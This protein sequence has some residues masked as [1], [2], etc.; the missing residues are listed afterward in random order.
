[1]LGPGLPMAQPLIPNN[2]ANIMLFFTALPNLNLTPDE[3][4]VYGQLFKQADTENV[5]VVTGEI[6][7]KFFEKTRLDSR[8]LGEVGNP[9]SP[10][11]LLPR[12]LE[13][14]A[15]NLHFLM[16]TDLADC[17]RRKPRLPYSRRLQHSLAFDRPC[18]TEP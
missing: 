13:S 17:R 12:T 15:T 4:R 8:I 9:F 18:P 2:S 3:K 5:G 10:E 11:C 14:A 1:M 16:N 6:A 7:V